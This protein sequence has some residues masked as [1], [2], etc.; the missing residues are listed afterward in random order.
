MKYNIGVMFLSVVLF[1]C[2]NDTEEQLYGSPV[3]NPEDVT[4]SFDVVPILSNNCYA[5]HSQANA[6]ANA[7]GI[8]LEGYE[9]IKVAV[10]NGLLME[11]ITHGPDASPMPKNAPRLSDCKI[12]TIRKWIEDGALNN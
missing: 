1:G 10:E 2:Y 7:A 6:P 11:S 8:V 4:F 12:N 3:C 5:C 9:K